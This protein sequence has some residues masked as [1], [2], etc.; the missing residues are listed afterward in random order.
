MSVIGSHLFKPK[1]HPRV[2]LRPQQS[3]QSHNKQLEHRGLHKRTLRRL[4]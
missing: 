3:Q 2:A 1:E 4:G